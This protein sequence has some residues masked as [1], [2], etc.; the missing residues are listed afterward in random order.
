MLKIFAPIKNFLK[1]TQEF[2]TSPR[3]ACQKTAKFS[4]EVQLSIGSFVR[5]DKVVKFEKDKLFE[6][7]PTV[8]SRTC[9]AK[10]GPTVTEYLIGNVGNELL[11]TDQDTFL[12]IAL[13]PSSIPMPSRL[14]FPFGYK[15][16]LNEWTYISASPV[17]YEL[18]DGL[19][20]TY[21]RLMK[22]GS[23][24]A[25]SPGKYFDITENYL[26]TIDLRK[27]NAGASRLLERNYL[28]VSNSAPLPNRF[29]FSPIA[30]HADLCSVYFMP[31]AVVIALGSQI[32]FYHYDNIRL[33]TFRNRF[34]THDV[35]VGVKPV[36]YTWQYVN[37]NGDPD[38]RFNNNFQIPIIEV[39]ELDFYFPDGVQF[40][41]A[42]TDGRAV[43]NFEETLLELGA[44]N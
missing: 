33:E 9:L 34:I 1:I 7:M 38:R 17:F 35:P 23:D 32:M 25:I 11:T 30:F 8:L 21:N 44:Q 27:R 14:R 41:T 2:A 10:L 3:G 18:S 26:E 13:S 43:E 4:N 42:F 16:K 36:D 28:S 29:N 6:N 40:H 24:L 15:K 37:K 31:D 20:Q 12:N 19:I 39:T 22:F 5:E